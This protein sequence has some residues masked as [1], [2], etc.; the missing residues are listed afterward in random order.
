MFLFLYGHTSDIRI[1]AYVL[2]SAFFYIKTNADYFLNYMAACVFQWLWYA[3]L[4][5]VNGKIFQSKIILVMF[6][7]WIYMYDL[8]DVPVMKTPTPTLITGH[9]HNIIQILFAHFPTSLSSIIHSYVFKS[10]TRM[11]L[12]HNNKHL[13]LSFKLPY[14]FLLKA[15]E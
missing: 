14:P 12:C 10:F 3:F 7:E 4:K 1:G 8:R 13:R 2:T 15:R 11:Y 6:I 5:F 9:T